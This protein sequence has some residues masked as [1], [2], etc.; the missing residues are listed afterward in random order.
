MN[1]E[2]HFA[3]P[4][5]VLIDDAS[6]K[7]YVSHGICLVHT[8]PG[9]AVFHGPALIGVFGMGVFGGVCKEIVCYGI[10]WLFVVFEVWCWVSEV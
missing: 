9:L 3:P 6:D 7:L 4:G 5:E 2:H 1:A 8:A 10:L